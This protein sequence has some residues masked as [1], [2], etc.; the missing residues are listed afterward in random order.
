MNWPRFSKRKWLTATNFLWWMLKNHRAQFCSSLVCCFFRGC[1]S[2]RKRQF[3]RC[4][5]THDGEKN[6]IKTGKIVYFL[7]SYVQLDLVFLQKYIRIGSGIYDVGLLDSSSKYT[8][9]YYGR[10]RITLW[11]E[12]SLFFAEVDLRSNGKYKWF[13][14]LLLRFSFQTAQRLCN[15]IR[16]CLQIVDFVDVWCGCLGLT[17]TYPAFDHGQILTI[18]AKEQNEKE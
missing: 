7:A 18:S 1:Y 11:T 5:H 9:V 6:S 4:I 8:C 13:F 3:I 16:Y 10:E 14:L 2:M 15:K 17:M 12:Y